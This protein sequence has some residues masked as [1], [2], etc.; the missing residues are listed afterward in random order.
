MNKKE[1]EILSLQGERIYQ[2]SVKDGN[3]KMLMEDGTIL[4]ALNPDHVFLVGEK[5]T[6]E[7]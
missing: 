7:L 6:V 4:L 3:L 1:R 5:T 2:I